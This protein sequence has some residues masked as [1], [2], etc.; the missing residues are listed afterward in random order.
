MHHTICTQ[1]YS[2][3]NHK[4]QIW[5]IFF[6]IKSM[7]NTNLNRLPHTLNGNKIVSNAYFKFIFKLCY[8]KNATMT[9]SLWRAPQLNEI[10]NNS[11]KE[12]IHLV[13]MYSVQAGSQGC[14]GLLCLSCLIHQPDSTETLRKHTACINRFLFNKSASV[15][16][17][18]LLL[19]GVCYLLCPDSCITSEFELGISE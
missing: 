9:H 7:E 18:F 10:R 13:R 5:T 17:T 4:I 3:P 11:L 15:H 19:G 14:D 2:L 12:A 8:I 1:K 6:P 16:V